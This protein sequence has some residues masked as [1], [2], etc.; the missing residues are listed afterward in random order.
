MNWLAK[1]NLNVVVERLGPLKSA[2]LL[3]FLIITS[4]F[5]GYRI[6]NFFHGF[7]QQKIQQQ[8]ARLTDLYQQQVDNIKRIN[9]LEVELEVE[10]LASDNSLKLLKDIEQQHFQVKKQ[11]A[12]YEKVMAPEKQADGVV[13]DEFI[14][15]ATTSPKH[16]RFRVI[17][18]QQEKNKRFAQGYVDFNLEGS[19]NGKPVTLKLSA[20]SS[21]TQANL[22]FNFQYFQIVEGEFSL[23]ENFKPEQVMLSATLPK[24]KWQAY[25][26]L[27]ATYKWQSVVENN[28]VQQP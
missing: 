10:R 13:I 7:Q 28:R 8:Q 16:Y 12:F 27:E 24:G 18:V 1:I 14:V 4:V 11:L 2:I 15:L 6:G 3:I 19:Q 20:I 25:N 5:C 21:L 23:P 26:R 22:S 17:L 9:I